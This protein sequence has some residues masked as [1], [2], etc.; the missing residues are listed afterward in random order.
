[1]LARS[2]FPVFFIGTF[3]ALIPGAIERGVVGNSLTEVLLN[4][5]RE[6]WVYLFLGLLLWLVLITGTQALL[7]RILP[8]SMTEEE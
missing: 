4:P 3:I 7:K 1:M 5:T 2:S 6:T 8:P